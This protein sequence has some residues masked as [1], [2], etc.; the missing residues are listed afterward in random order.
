MATALIA[1]LLGVLTGCAHQVHVESNVPTAEVRVDGVV[2]GRAGAGASFVE[3][4]GPWST[5][6]I[7][8]SAAG[9]RTARR[10]V[11]P[12]ITD[13]WVGIPAMCSMIS[14]C[15]VASCAVPVSLWVVSLSPDNSGGQCL[16]WGCASLSTAWAG[17]SAA[18][19]AW[20]GQRLPDVIT[21]PLEPVDDAMAH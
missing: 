16:G 5:Y 1:V 19:A 10:R 15:A 18:L 14:G 21:I 13:P 6:D 3:R 4:A 2:V 9:Y 12:S 17:G 8:V 7:E 20:G 11:T